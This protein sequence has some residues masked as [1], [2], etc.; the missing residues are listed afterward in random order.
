[1]KQ[2]Y[3]EPVVNIIQLSVSDII[4]TSNGNFTDDPYPY[5]FMDKKEKR[6]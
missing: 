2:I 4:A 6:R 1:M 3:E 5:N